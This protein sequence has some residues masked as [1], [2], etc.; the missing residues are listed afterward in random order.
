MFELI[1]IVSMLAAPSPLDAQDL[2]CISDGQCYAQVINESGWVAGYGDA[3]NGMSQHGFVWT[4]NYLVHIVP[5]NYPNGGQVWAYGINDLGDVVGYSS[6]GPSFHAFL[7]DGEQMQD[8]GKPDWAAADY[9]R[10]EDI[11]NNGWVVGMAGGVPYDLR[12][13]IKHDAVWDEIPTFGGNE[14][15]AYSINDLNDVAGWTRNEEGKFRAFAIPQ[16]NV[17]LMLDIGDLGGGAAKAFDVNNNRQIVGQSKGVDDFFHAFI[18]SQDEGMID[19][20]TLGGNESCAWSV[21]DSGVVVG[22][23][24]L[25]NGETHGFIYM[26]GVMYDANHFIVPDI[27]ITIVNVRDINSSGELAA[28]GEYPDGTKRPYLLTPMGTVPEDVNG[29]GTV[30][31]TDLLAV[32]AAWGPCKDCHEDVNGDSMVDVSDILAIIAAWN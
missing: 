6:T 19:L 23:S 25:S 3:P 13:F 31:V 30:D 12:G 17:D 29:D 14:S 10:A 16:G 18:W 8:L 21:S 26:D 2:G 28:I 1:P 9:S 11:N 5:L 15:R 24:E 32:V 7:W 4:G 20:G 22:K 27:D